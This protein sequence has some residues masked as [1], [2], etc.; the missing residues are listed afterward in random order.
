[1][2]RKTKNFANYI[3]RVPQVLGNNLDCVGDCAGEATD[4]GRVADEGDASVGKTIFPSP[5]AKRA[6]VPWTLAPLASRARPHARPSMYTRKFIRRRTSF[7]RVHILSRSLAPP[8][9]RFR[10]L[11]GE[12]HRMALG[13][14]RLTS[15]T[16]PV[17]ANDGTDTTSVFPRHP[18]LHHPRPER[19]LAPAKYTCGER[20][21]W[22][23]RD[24]CRDSTR[25]CPGLT[26]PSVAI[27]ASPP[28]DPT[29]PP[30][31]RSRPT[32]PRASSSWCTRGGYRCSVRSCRGTPPLRR[33]S[34]GFVAA[35]NV[36]GAYRAAS[37]KRHG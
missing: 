19:G 37:G 6:E 34:C 8:L 13:V 5:L 25:A 24:P 28:S 4:A 22:N 7:P 21:R 31:P 1:M 17:S 36:A 14:S 33:E 11:V 35:E 2:K 15:A 18:P 20:S 12:G 10:T 29:S 26:A 27:E 3:L 9:A 23:G 32:R 30:P 16:V